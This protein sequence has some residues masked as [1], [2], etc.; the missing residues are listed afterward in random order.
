MM[1]G[2]LL[3]LLLLLLY[4]PSHPTYFAGDDA[5]TA[6]VSPKWIDIAHTLYYN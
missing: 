1:K 5:K 6:Q 3:L 2:A 4:L